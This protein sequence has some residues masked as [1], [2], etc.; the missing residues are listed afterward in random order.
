MLLQI[1]ASQSRWRLCR[2][3]LCALLMAGLLASGSAFGQ[4]AGNSQQDRMKACNAQAGAQKLSGDARKSFMSDC[5][6]GKTAETTTVPNSQQ[7]KMKQCNADAKTKGLTGADRKAF[8]QKCLS[9]DS[10]AV[11]ASSPQGYQWIG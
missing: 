10:A 8:M 5:L 2:G 9:A 1:G 7:Q 11:K 3:V 6:S 4:S